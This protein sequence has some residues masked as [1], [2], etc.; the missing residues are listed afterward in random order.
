MYDHGRHSYRKNTTNT[1]CDATGFKVKKSQ[2]K[3]M[4]DGTYVIKEEWEPRDPQDFPAPVRRQK[5]YDNVRPP[6]IQTVTADEVV[7]I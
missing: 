2:T 1:I 3:K 7:P 6:K 4:W 5:V